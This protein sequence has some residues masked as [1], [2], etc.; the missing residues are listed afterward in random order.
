METDET[1]KAAE[2]FFAGTNEKP[3]LK[4]SEVVE[5]MREKRIELDCKGVLMCCTEESVSSVFDFDS[6]SFS[7]KSDISLML[8]HNGAAQLAHECMS[9]HS[10][11]AAGVLAEAAYRKGASGFIEAMMQGLCAGVCQGEDA[12]G[13]EGES[14][15]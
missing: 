8:V 5:A 7:K 13:K 15:E 2:E 12:D 1:T 4:L 11:Q 14:H 6:C 10:P 9:Q 3:M